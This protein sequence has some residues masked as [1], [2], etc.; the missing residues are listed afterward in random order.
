MNGESQ[1]L[2]RAF[3]FWSGAALV[4]A[5]MI[6]TGILLTPGAA[7]A[8]LGSHLSAILLWVVGGLLALC[9]ALTLAEMASAIPKVGGEYVYVDRA[10]GPTAG[11]TYGWATLVVGFVGPTAAVALA[12][13]KFLLAGVPDEYAAS[14]ARLPFPADP[15]LAC[16]LVVLLTLVHCTGQRNSA[17]VQTA[18]TGF[19][20]AT[21][22]VFALL[23]FSYAFRMGTWSNLSE[24][25]DPAKAPL[26]TASAS[27]A[28]H[29][30]TLLT[31]PGKAVLSLV[32]ITYAYVG[33]NGAAYVAGEARDAEKL[34][35]RSLL[36][37]CL[38]VTVLYVVIALAFAGTFT[39]G[40]LTALKSKADA[41]DEKEQKNEQPSP[42]EV[43]A[44]ETLNVL[45]LEG[46]VR[47][48]PSPATRPA[49]SALF[50]VGLIAT[51]S[52]FIVTGSR[53]MMAMAVGGHFLPVAASWNVRR[54]APVAALLLL[55]VP[56]AGVV[57]YG[58]LL[59]LINLLGTGLNALGIVFAASIF[60]L[61]RRSDYHP[62]FH[63]PLY[64]LPPLGY[65]IGCAMI[66][67]VSLWTQ[68]GMTLTSLGVILA[69]A[70][71][72]WLVRGRLQRR[73]GP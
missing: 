44:R 25:A 34:V 18:T 48:V 4:A 64:P 12:A 69:G 40:E 47:S 3:G 2:P 35:P 21:L 38:A 31:M 16:F 51:I 55:G 43:R 5:S 66:L 22:A 61:R 27:V 42:D 20:Y 26:S 41:A 73:Q 57:W 28:S 68:P 37:G 65:L 56:T 39:V 59:D 53:V 29:W 23:G 7:A 6:G 24:L 10:F 15:A 46:V 49:A 67:G 52:A 9:G 17:W 36:A 33:W 30:S 62:V 54:N 32:F 11:F 1:E 71:I 14:L 72:Y 58:K 13:A 63:V 60:A 45:A 50:G 19:K 70:P 8:A